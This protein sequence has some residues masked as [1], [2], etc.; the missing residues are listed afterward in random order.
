MA[1][2]AQDFI[3]DGVGTFLDALVG[4]PQ[5]AEALSAQP[6]VSLHIVK[7]ILVVRAVGLD[8]Q[9]MTRAQ[10]V[11]DVAA[12]RDLAAEL[13]ALKAAVAEQRPEQAL[14]DG[15]LMAEPTREG[16]LS[17]AIDHDE[18]ITGTRCVGKPVFPLPLRERV[19]V[20]RT[21]G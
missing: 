6:G 15:R 13:Q 18:N 4:E 8:D 19:A 11:G 17:G 2:G 5:Q 3:E 12:E 20:R 16:E 10:E 21:V 9:A 1:A 14:G 7:T